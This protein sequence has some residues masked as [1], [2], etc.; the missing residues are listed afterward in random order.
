M[1]GFDIVSNRARVMMHSAA[2]MLHKRFYES[3][4]VKKSSGSCRQ[5]DSQRGDAYNGDFGTKSDPLRLENTF[6]PLKCFSDGQ[7]RFC[8]EPIS[9]PISFVSLDGCAVRS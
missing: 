3:R 6:E 5:S 9:S 2:I 8:W 1:S 4:Y 7:A